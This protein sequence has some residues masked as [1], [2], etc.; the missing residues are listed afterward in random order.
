MMEHHSQEKGSQL[1]QLFAR[2]NRE[3][4]AHSRLILPSVDPIDDVMQEASVVIWEKQDQ[5][6][7][8]DEFL[9]AKTIVRNISFRIVASWC[10]T[11]MS[12]MT[13]WWNNSH[14]GRDRAGGR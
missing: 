11:V 2:H 6:R 3:L 12:L 1:L 14:G 7:H 9:L 4:R 10:V 13:N 5:L 8:E